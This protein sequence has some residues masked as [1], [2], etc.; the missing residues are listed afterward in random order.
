MLSKLKP[1]P[2]LL[3]VEGD[4]ENQKFLLY[5][6]KKYFRIEIC[7]SAEKCYELLHKERSDIIVMDISIKGYKNG[8]VLTK[9]LKSHPLFSKIPIVC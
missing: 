7:D 2:K 8:L 4:L 3:V 6:F 9:E 5:C 1:L